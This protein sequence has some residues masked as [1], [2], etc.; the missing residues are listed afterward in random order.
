MIHGGEYP[1]QSSVAFLPMIDMNPSDMSCILSTLH[2]VS[3]HARKQDQFLVITFDQPLYL[4]ALTILQQEKDNSD[5]Q[6]I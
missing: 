4:K 2:Y 5:L 6:N 1:G 3:A